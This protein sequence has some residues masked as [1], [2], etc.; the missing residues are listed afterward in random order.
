LKELNLPAYSFKITGKTGAE[1]IFDPV[2]RK[3]VR[4]TPEE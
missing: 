1:M 2:R 3:Y 4:L